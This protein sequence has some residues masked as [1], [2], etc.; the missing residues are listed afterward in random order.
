MNK[1]QHGAEQPERDTGEPKFNPRLLEMAQAFLSSRMGAAV[2][3]T[4]PALNCIVLPEGFC[5][6]CGI[7]HERSEPVRFPVSPDGVAQL[8]AKGQ[9]GDETCEAGLGFVGA[10]LY[11]GAQFVGYVFA[12]AVKDVKLFEGR[13]FTP[14]R[15]R[16]ERPKDIARR[17]S[18]ELKVTPDYWGRL[19]DEV[20]LSVATIASLVRD[21]VA[22]EGDA[23][24][25]LN[26]LQKRLDMPAAY[27]ERWKALIA[28]VCE[29]MGADAGALVFPARA[30]SEELEVHAFNLSHS[31]VTGFLA[32]SVLACQIP[33]SHPVLLRDEAGFPPPFN[34]WLL[35][36]EKIRAVASMSIGLEGG[37]YGALHLFGFRNEALRSSHLNSMGLIAREIGRLRDRWSLAQDKRLKEQELGIIRSLRRV[38]AQDRLSVLRHLDALLGAGFGIPYRRVFLAET[39]SDRLRDPLDPEHGQ[40]EHLLRL[41]REG[42]VSG[43]VVEVRDALELHPGSAVLDIGIR[44]LIAVPLQ[45]EGQQ[46][47]VLVVGLRRPAEL[48]TGL[49]SSLEGIAGALGGILHALDLRDAVRSTRAGV[50]TTLLT[51]LESR[52][53]FLADH[54]RRVGVYCWAIA[55]GLGLPQSEAEEAFYAGL[56][57]DVG[58][59]RLPDDV[60]QMQVRRRESDTM[61]NPASRR[62]ADLAADLLEQ[63]GVSRGLA[64]LVRHHHEWFDGSG[65]P[66]RLRGEEIPLGSRI[67]CLADGLDESLHLSADERRERPRHLREALQQV[68]RLTGSRYD[69]SLVSDFV[70][71]LGDPAFQALLDVDALLGMSLTAL[72]ERIL[73]Q[74]GPVREREKAAGPAAPVSKP[75]P[76]RLGEEPLALTS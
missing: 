4:D 75:V 70:R 66:R 38:A 15:Q 26:E 57:H 37:R 68:A 16:G 23:V 47:G 74:S 41:A 48:D 17:F 13:L 34:H 67:I 22:A 32:D 59:L 60:L 63:A 69:G 7:C 5:R 27:E 18:M 53:K 36:E 6:D 45:A 72:I 43:R 55:R 54:S 33:V 20:G 49:R 11:A 73:G 21:R 1:S 46:V 62:H 52:C 14:G 25:L 65:F 64:P 56:A 28:Y 40:D 44:A 30:G 12:G 51:A 50:V 71:R 24:A 9:P 3:T 42:H 61:N 10:P 2:F 39:G 29:E 31:F 76:R 8:V 58:F 19:R 35:I